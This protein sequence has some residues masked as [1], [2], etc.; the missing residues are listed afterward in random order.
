M[1]AHRARDQLVQ[2]GRD[3]PGAW[4]QAEGFRA[5]RGAGFDW[6]DWCYLPLAGAYAIVSGGGSNRVPLARMGDVARIG[7]LA[8]WRMTQGIYRFDPSVFAAVIDTPVTG[9]LPVDAL[10]RLPEWCVY[11]ETSGLQAYASE[12]HGFWAHLE[13]DSNNGRKE[14]RLLLDVDPVP[15]G[16]PLHLGVGSLAES[17]AQ[18]TDQ[19]GVHAVSL[20]LSMPAGEVRREWRNLAE[21]LVSLL[22]YLCSTSDM[23]GRHGQPGNPKPVSTRP[24]GLR[25]F[26]ADGPRTWDVGVRMGSALR[27]AYQAAE[28]GSASDHVGPR[29]HVRRAHWHG[30]RSGPRKAADGTDISAEQ[31]PFELRWLPPIPVNLPDVADLAATVRPVK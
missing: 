2:A 29:G 19:A 27:S 18:A 6:P 7:A 1:T 12:L 11:V 26:P 25:L 3:Y 10:M 30:F 15:V 21:P 20:G 28:T 31:R 9:D 8:T 4:G 16:V 13:S 24:D 5:A 17:I 23:A 22:L 14:L